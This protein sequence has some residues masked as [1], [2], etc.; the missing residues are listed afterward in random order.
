VL[1]EVIE[2]GRWASQD[3]RGAELGERLGRTLDELPVGFLSGRQDGGQ[4]S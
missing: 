1:P 3:G 4:L 2:V